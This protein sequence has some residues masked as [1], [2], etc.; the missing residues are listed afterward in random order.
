M[1]KAGRG[2][3]E[4][5]KEGGGGRA[6]GRERE[7]MTEVGK[8]VKAGCALGG[9]EGQRG[10]GIGRAVGR[11]HGWPVGAGGF[12]RG[13]KGLPVWAPLHW[14]GGRG[15]QNRRQKRGCRF[16]FGLQGGGYLV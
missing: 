6:G 4:R 5:E 12:G 13:K 3:K 14:P 11:S 16:V 1:G 10:F 8:R 9:P 7:E 2:E 15:V